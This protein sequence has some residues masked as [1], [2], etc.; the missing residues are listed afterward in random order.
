MMSD[1][2]SDED[3]PLDMDGEMDSDD[4]DSEGGDGDIESL[5]APAP[6]QPS[7]AAEFDEEDIQFS[8]EWMITL[9]E[10]TE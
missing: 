3:L 7:G 1:S 9:L 10:L 5:F 4:M 2:D 6:D 8:G